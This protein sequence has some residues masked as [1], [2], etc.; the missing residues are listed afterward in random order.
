[1]KYRFLFI[2]FIFSLFKI[3]GQNKFEVIEKRDKI[4]NPLEFAFY[5]QNPTNFMVCTK[6]KEKELY[7]ITPSSGHYALY[8]LSKELALNILH[9]NKN[10][11]LGGILETDSQEEIE[12]ITP[13]NIEEKSKEILE[14]FNKNFKLNVDYN[15]TEEDINK[16]DERV[17]KTTWNKENVFLLNF[18]MMEVTKR[19]FN[20]PNWTFYKVETFNPFF[21]VQYI[22]RSG[23][24]EDYYKWLKKRSQFNF[25]LFTGLIY[26]DGTPRFPERK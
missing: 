23:Y 5:D 9:S 17:K 20:F 4:H 15:P 8:V 7:Y 10:I 25:R 11:D 18:Y 2:I 16:I 19:I 6:H 22:G 12:K 14:R 26:G 13:E 3:M 21:E 24:G 1:M